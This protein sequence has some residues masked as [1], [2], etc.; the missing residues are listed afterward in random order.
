MLQLGLPWYWG[1]VAVRPAVLRGQ[2]G[3][4]CA[5]TGWTSAGYRL[6]EV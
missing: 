2:R 1:K 6:A 5:L 3:G 4:W